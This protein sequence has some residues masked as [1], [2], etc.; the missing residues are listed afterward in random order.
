VSIRKA[1]FL[2]L[3][4]LFLA[5]LALGSEAIPNWRAPSVWSPSRTGGVH[6][7][8]DVT[9][10]LPFIG[11]TPCRVADTRGN[12]FAGSYGPPSLVANAMRSFTITGQCGIPASAAA[13]SF[14]FGALNV[15]GAGDLRIFP[16]GGSVPPVSTLN[17]NAST[18]N[19][20]NAAVVPL[21]T[22]GITVQADAVTID[23]IIDVNGYY[24]ATSAAN[25]LAFGEQFS[26]FGDV[27]GGGTGVLDVRNS[28]ASASARAA[29][30]SCASPGDGSTG[31]AG[32][33]TATTGLTAGIF[34]QA[35][36]TTALSAGI[37]GWE[38]ATTGAVFGVEGYSASTGFNSAGVLGYAGARTNTESFKQVGVRGESAS[39]IG[40]LG[41]TNVA[42]L[43]AGVGGLVMN[44]AGAVVYEGV[45]G[46]AFSGLGLSYVGGLG[47]TGTKSFYEPHPTDPE[48]VIRYV[49]LEGNE[50]GTYFR[51]TAHVVHGQAV[52]TVPEDFRIVT[53][54]EGLTVQLTPVGVLTMMA[55]ESEDLNQ[56]TVRSSKDVTFHYL[57]QGVRR[58]YKDFEIVAKSPFFQPRSPDDRM[59]ESLSD[60]E[61]A[62]LIANGTYNPDGTV[63]M[64]TAER[65]G[66]AKAW[67]DREEQA[68]AAAAASATA[69]AARLAETK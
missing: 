22:G 50:S 17:Y 20:A 49:S 32:F 47:G 30:F 41:I 1:S 9:N 38:T 24:P 19:I 40:V 51:G 21:G 5:G 15:G 34:G 67:R 66:W 45:A 35:S 11:V 39:G 4:S 56:I 28:E 60:G 31:L 23:L 59:N 63:N 68:K 65:L 36:S 69:R 52:I 18:P 54:E 26:L 44:T 48:K 14:N 58:N 61:K 62:R 16:A 46:N 12:G 55:V 6:T 3:I 37:S 33:E 57:V 64:A 27:V 43:S 42:G 2:G 25:P 10:P 53:D 13:V 7:M 29:Y 8:T